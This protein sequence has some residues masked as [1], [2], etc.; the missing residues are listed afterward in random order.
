MFTYISQLLSYIINNF[1]GPIITFLV[2]IPILNVLFVI[3]PL[4]L[5]FLIF[6]AKLIKKFIWGAK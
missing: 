6:S 2:R 5:T 1:F 3:I 4:C